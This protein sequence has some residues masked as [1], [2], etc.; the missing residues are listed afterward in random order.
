MFEV[1]HHH[2]NEYAPEYA[3]PIT[4][5][6]DSEYMSD[7]IT[8]NST[9]APLAADPRFPIGKFD[10]EFEV[11]PELRT[12]RISIIEDHPARMRE[13]VEGLSDA[14]LDTAYRHEGWT[15]RQ[16]VHHVA[17]SHMNAFIRF[18]LSLTEYDPPTIKPYREERWA[19]LGDAKLPVETSLR[20]LEAI[21]ERWI[22]L[23][24]S[25]SYSDFQKEFIHPE[26]GFW[27]LDGALALYAWH[28]EHH[29][30]HI[31]TLRDR[32]GW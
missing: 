5:L 12:A 28:S 25:I 8:S 22:A 4:V 3:F 15:I 7:S 11:S 31:T 9:A 20:L 23:L 13:A 29:T 32:M 2:D 10:M 30:A 19:E 14:Q 18:K 1:L 21:H 16:V 6:K 17:D 27:T 24:H 26:T